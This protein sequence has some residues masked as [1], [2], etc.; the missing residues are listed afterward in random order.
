MGFMDWNDRGRETKHNKIGRIPKG[1]EQQDREGKDLKR[2]KIT[3]LIERRMN[4]D[5]RVLIEWK[6][7]LLVFVRWEGGT[8]H[9]ARIVLFRG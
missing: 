9:G 4:D 8:T 3:G 6:L 7:E 1:K 2:Q 5:K